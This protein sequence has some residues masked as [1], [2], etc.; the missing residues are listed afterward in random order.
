MRSEAV[1]VAPPCFDRF[2]CMSEAAEEM[3][4]EAFVSQPAVEAFDEP[5]LHG[6][7]RLNVMPFDLA[8]LLLLKNG[9]RCQL[10]AVVADDHARVAAPFGDAVKLTRRADA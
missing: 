8:L 10:R 4:I 3:L 1:V 7:A 6:L 2:S 9:V 5:V